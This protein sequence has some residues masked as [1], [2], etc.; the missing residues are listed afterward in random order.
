MAADTSSS[1]AAITEVVEGAAAAVAALSDEPIPATFTAATD[2]ISVDAMTYDVT[3]PN[4]V[5][6]AQ[7]IYEAV[8]MTN[9]QQNF[10]ACAQGGPS[11]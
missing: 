1:A 3:A 6:R 7:E 9:R 5:A 2:N 4:P 8:S 11:R 10:L